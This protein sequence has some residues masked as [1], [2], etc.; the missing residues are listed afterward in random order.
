[1]AG[2]IFF[3]LACVWVLLAFAV[4]A[5]AW[6][7]GCSF[8]EFLAYALVALPVTFLF[9]VLIAWERNRLSPSVAG[10]ADADG[11]SPRRTIGVPLMRSTFAVGVVVAALTVGLWPARTV[12]TLEK[13]AY[14]GV[15][16]DACVE[17]ETFNE[18]QSVFDIAFIDDS[19]ADD[20]D[21][22]PEDGSAATETMK[23]DTG[24]SENGRPGPA[25]GEPAAKADRS[26]GAAPAV[27][28][29]SSRREMSRQA[30]PLGE[31]SG[32]PDGPKITTNRVD[33]SISD[34]R[35]IPR[36]LTRGTNE[37]LRLTRD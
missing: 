18:C 10:E 6:Q 23:A 27:G 4:A 7:A 14:S 8:L 20:T 25:A 37:P 29:T 24:S 2:I 32:Q 30:K 12:V 13:A 19:D 5:A 35:A 31:T 34:E 22:T 16:F 36:R 28:R 33:T 11:E 15:K 1:M 9:V 26:P 3:S 17:V 21:P